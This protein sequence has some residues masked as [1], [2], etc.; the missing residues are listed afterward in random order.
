VLG[1]QSV[2]HHLLGGH[3]F[4]IAVVVAYPIHIRGL[5]MWQEVCDDVEGELAKALSDHH[6]RGH[7]NRG[8][9]AL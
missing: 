8:G 7:S 4:I 1:R 6:A 9:C 5:L 2:A 3:G